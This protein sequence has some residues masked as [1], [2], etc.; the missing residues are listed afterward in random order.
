MPPAQKKYY[1]YQTRF[2]SKNF[3][4][5]FVKI[6]RLVLK[7]SQFLK[8]VCPWDKPIPTRVYQPCLALKNATRVEYLGCITHLIVSAT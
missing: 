1:V 6:A 3:E 8:N 7:L 5:R 2:H 4:T